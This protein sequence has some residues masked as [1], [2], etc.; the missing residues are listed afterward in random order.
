MS[1]FPM[2]SLINNPDHWSAHK[3]KLGQTVEFH[4]LRK[5][6][7]ARGTYLVTRELPERNGEFDYRIRSPDEEHERVARESELSVL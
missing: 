2:P 1:R 3:F 4:P 6:S 7:A 5:F